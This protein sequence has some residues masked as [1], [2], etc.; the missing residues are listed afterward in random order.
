MLDIALTQ[1]F[2]INIFFFICDT[3]LTRG[4][5]FDKHGKLR[6]YLTLMTLEWEKQL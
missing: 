4:H 2:N 1:S 3:A 5:D 6:H